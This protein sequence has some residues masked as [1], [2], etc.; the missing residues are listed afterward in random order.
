MDPFATVELKPDT[1]TTPVA[2]CVGQPDMTLCN[3]VTTPDRW[4]DICVGGTCVSP[5]CGDASCN[6]PAP[7]FSIP[8][9]SD[10]SHLQIISSGSEPIVADL[11]TGLHWQGC[12]AGRSGEGWGSYP[13]AALIPLRR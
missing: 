10:H 13:E 12:D 11:V 3:I 9:N 7:H 4:Y 5:G 8:A 6:A 1:D 2:S